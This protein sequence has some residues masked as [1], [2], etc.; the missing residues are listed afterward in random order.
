MEQR[1]TG[2]GG[3]FFKA[4]D[5]KALREWYREHLGLATC[6]GLGKREIRVEP[7]LLAE[8]SRPVACDLVLGAIRYA[9]SGRSTAAILDSVLDAVPVP[10]GSPA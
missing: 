10:A 3:V 6:D 4:R 5:A 9:V 7:G 1:V 8:L 2:V